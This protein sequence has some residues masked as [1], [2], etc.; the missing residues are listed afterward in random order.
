MFSAKSFLVIIAL[1]KATSALKFDC[2]DNLDCTGNSRQNGGMNCGCLPHPSNPN[3]CA[4]DG[5]K[6]FQSLTPEGCFLKGG[7]GASVWGDNSPRTCFMNK[8]DCWSDCECSY[9]DGLPD[10][11]YN[12]ANVNSPSNA[13]GNTLPYNN[14]G[15]TGWQKCFELGAKSA[16]IWGHSFWNVYQDE[17]GTGSSALSPEDCWALVPEPAYTVPNTATMHQGARVIYQCETNAALGCDSFGSGFGDPHFRT[18]DGEVFDFQGECDLV[19]LEAPTADISI[20]VRTKLNKEKTFSYIEAAAIEING[21]TMEIGDYGSII[22]NGVYNADDREIPATVGGYPLELERSDKKTHTY[23]IHINRSLQHYIELKSF[24]FMVGVNV[25][26]PNKDME[27]ATGIFGSAKRGG[28]KIGRD[29]VTN[30]TDLDAY[31]KEW[32]VQPNEKALF[33][34]S[35]EHPGVCLM[36]TSDAM[37]IKRIGGVSLEAAEKACAHM[38]LN[39]KACMTDVMASNDLQM[40]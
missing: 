2:W 8:Y 33:E 6:C 25:H 24:T 26:L 34:T 38:G 32:I 16:S 3:V 37:H 13:M 20:H 5:L 35:D 21:E 22:V 40:A 31:G 11:W 19:F 39:K 30:F 4:L 12:S 29:G 28:D 9:E 10:N 27:G 23:R 18:Q 17:C 15:V 14:G 7:L 36:P 1:A